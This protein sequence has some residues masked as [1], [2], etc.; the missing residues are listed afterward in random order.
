MHQ[1]ERITFLGNASQ[2]GI[3]VFSAL[4]IPFHHCPGR[5]KSAYEAA[6]SGAGITVPS[7]R[8]SRKQKP[9]PVITRQPQSATVNVGQSVT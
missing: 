2:F 5:Q 6:L 3:G 4:Q 9:N 7:A 1:L 8:P